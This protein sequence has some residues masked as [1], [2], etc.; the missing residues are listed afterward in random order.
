[1][2]QRHTTRRRAFSLVELLTVIFIIALLIGILVPSVTAARTAAKRATTAKTIDVIK[3]GL[4]MF[5]N[6]NER[7]FRRTNGYPPSFEHPP[8]PGYPDFDEQARREGG[9][10]FLLEGV[11]P[12]A[13]GAHWLPTML[14]GKD[15]LGYVQRRAVPKTADVWKRPWLWYDNDALAAEGVDPIPRASLYLDPG[16]TRTRLTKDLPGRPPSDTVFPSREQ[17]GT[18]PVIVDAFDQPI[19]YYVANPNGKPTN[20]LEDHRK[21]QNRYEGG[22]QRNGPPFYFHE[23]NEGFTGRSVEDEALFGWDFSGRARPHPIAQSG[24]DMTAVEILDQYNNGPQ[25]QR[26]TFARYILDRKI[27]RNIQEPNAATQNT[28]L[29]PVNADSY[30]LISAGPDGLYGTKDDVSNLPPF[31]DN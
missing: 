6:E 17:I 23:D 14:M 18:L 28:P 19:L 25:D 31:P 3:T 4:E 15:A 20:M 26:E 13:Y 9:Y 22:P 10:P 30:L 11:F 12:R 2:S 27:W 8:I 5:R 21:P 1:M 24:A 16:N 29:R 7:D